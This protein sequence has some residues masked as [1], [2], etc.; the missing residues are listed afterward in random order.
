MPPRFDAVQTA[1]TFHIC[2]GEYGD[3]RIHDERSVPENLEIIRLGCGA[4]AE[5][6]RKRRTWLAFYAEFCL[7]RVR[8]QARCL[9][10][11]NRAR[12]YGQCRWPSCLGSVCWRVKREAKIGA[13]TQDYARR[14]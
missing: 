14:D 12:H 7:N 1:R 11:H 2:T 9:L 13:W 4:P 5:E 10:I 8:Q 3:A 6:F